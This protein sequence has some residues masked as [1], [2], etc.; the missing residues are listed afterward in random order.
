MGIRYKYDKQLNKMIVLGFDKD[1]FIEN[2][3]IDGIVQGVPVTAIAENAF[4]N[5]KITSVIIPETIE[6]I[7]IRAFAN[8]TELNSVSV[9]DIE[10]EKTQDVLLIQS[11]AFSHCVNLSA[12][13]AWS[14]S[15]HIQNYAFCN[16]R[17]L[18]FPLMGIIR[19]EAGSFY[20]C[21]QIYSLDF[22]EG[23]ILDENSLLNCHLEKIKILG[24]VK[25]H[26]TVLAQIKTEK[27]KLYCT[28]NSSLLDLIYEGYNI[29]TYSE[30]EEFALRMR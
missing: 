7:G 25:I 15:V 3:K 27:I 6:K 10:A 5:T 11:Y 13:N 30:A 26:K 1:V 24:N 16:C 8:C 17:S 21:Y 18:R 12:F 29:E 22:D 2:L 9:G 28:R 20:N 23:A 19:L 4:R 14:Y